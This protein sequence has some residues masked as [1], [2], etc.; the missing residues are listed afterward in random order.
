MN[1]PIGKTNLIVTAVI[2][3]QTQVSLLR[4]EMAENVTL[5][6]IKNKVTGESGHLYHELST[7]K[8]D[9]LEENVWTDT[10]SLFADE[11]PESDE[12]QE[13]SFCG[14]ASTPTTRTDAIDEIIGACCENG[15]TYRAG[16]EAGATYDE[17]CWGM[18]AD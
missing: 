13:L 3:Q 16:N 1:R 9:I 2:Y 14:D 6:H 8:R 15:L 4:D 18:Y 7:D 11:H 17:Q 10:P 12:I 5:M